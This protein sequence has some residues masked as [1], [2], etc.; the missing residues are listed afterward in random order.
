MDRMKDTPEQAALLSIYRRALFDI[1]LR[2][3][4]LRMRRVDGRPWRTTARDVDTGNSTQQLVHQPYEMDSNRDLWDYFNEHLRPFSQ[5]QPAKS[6][7]AAI[8]QAA[9]SHWA[10]EKL[11]ARAPITD[12]ASLYAEY[13][14]T[15]ESVRLIAKR[16]QD[17]DD[18]AAV[19]ALAS[20]GHCAARELESLPRE[21]VRAV[22]QRHPSWPVSVSAR[23][24]ART[25]NFP[26]LH[27]IDLGLTCGLNVRPAARWDEK[28]IQ[29][30][31]AVRLLA[32]LK[33]N[34]EL[35]QFLQ[36]VISFQKR[37]RERPSRKYAKTFAKIAPIPK[38]VEDATNLDP[39]SKATAPQWWDVAREAFN[40]ACPKPDRHPDFNLPGAAVAVSET[41]PARRRGVIV[42][43]IRVTFFALASAART[44]T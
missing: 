27:D 29:D 32:T 6:G 24:P 41:D 13:L 12:S 19:E 22:A 39:F 43:K 44:P 34:R 7:D 21:L 36:A 26:Y 8:D 25:K 5:P 42:E 14:Q 23:V 1:G 2:L 33:F 38:W 37:F 35:R 9:A 18:E 40:E 10:D 15:F 3:P 16:A 31:H 11:K 30:Q 17:H 4:L 20:I 28:L